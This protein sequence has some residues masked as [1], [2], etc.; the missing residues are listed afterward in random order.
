MGR[1]CE[2]TY[3]R[4][5]VRSTRVDYNENRLL[6]RYCRKNNISMADAMRQ[7]LNLGY[8]AATGQPLIKKGGIDDGVEE[9]LTPP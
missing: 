6:A 2:S 3:P 5:I 1:N 7:L 4:D 8:Q 9:P